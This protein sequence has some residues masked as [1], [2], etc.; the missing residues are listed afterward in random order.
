MHVTDRTPHDHDDHFISDLRLL[1]AQPSSTGQ[2]EELAVTARLVA[3]MLRRVGMDV[4]CV[5]TPGA[6]VILGWREGHLPSR[7]LLYHH[8]D[9]A[10]AGPWRS[11]FHEPFQLAEREAALY[12]RGV[13]DGKGPLVAHVQAIRALLDAD[14][15]L[16]CGIIMVVEGESLR[17]SPYLADVIASHSE[18]LQS[19]VCLS[20]AGERDAEG[21]PICYGGSKGLL[22]VQLSARSAAQP[23]PPGVAASVPNPVWRLAWALNNIKGDDEDIRITGFYDAIAGP[24][25]GER[26][27]LRQVSLD[28]TGRLAGWHISDFLFGMR[29]PSLVR[30]EVTLPTCNITSFTSEPVSDIPC[31][32]TA[33]A[34]QLDFQLV[35]EQQPAQILALLRKHLVE[36]SLGDILVEELPGGYAPIRTDMA[37]SFVQQLIAAGERIYGTALPT[38]PLGSFVQPLHIFAEHLHLPVVAVGLARPTSN[39][40]GPNEHLPLDDLVR[41]SQLLMEVLIA[42]SKH[43]GQVEISS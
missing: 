9:V 12:A 32:P 7:L 15:E 13:A 27:M 36:R 26:E 34:A 11:W 23:L 43:L 10:P 29:G 30:S 28:E 33:A 14:G 25:R 20:T 39:I 42:Y 38:L 37:Q 21:I 16:P 22:R 19:D 18:Q 4:I 1:C 40:Y 3:D 2:T 24:N 6:P 35:P 5:R 8:Y 31:V 17:G 41:H